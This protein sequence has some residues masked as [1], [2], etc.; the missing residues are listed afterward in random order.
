[1][2]TLTILG[3]FYE[4]TKQYL[5]WATIPLVLGEMEWNRR[6]MFGL[7]WHVKVLL[8][9]TLISTVFLWGISKIA[10]LFS[11]IECQN[12]PKISQLLSKLPQLYSYTVQILYHQN[13]QKIKNIQV[14]IYKLYSLKK[15]CHRKNIFV[16]P[17]FWYF[18]WMN[19]WIYTLHLYIALTHL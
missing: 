14:K 17:N 7:I 18:S 4:K 13:I 3:Q 9:I 12:I 8:I 19:E 11:I 5:I 1:M 2:E 15:W 6:N 16:S 10:Q